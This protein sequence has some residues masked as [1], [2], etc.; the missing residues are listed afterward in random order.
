MATNSAPADPRGGDMDSDRSSV[1]PL[2]V[3]VRDLPC[4]DEHNYKV[5]ELCRACEKAAG[6]QSMD[7]AQRI[8]GLWRL[9]PANMAARTSLLM[10]GIAIRGLQVSLLDTNP[11]LIKGGDGSE[12]KTTR[13]TISDIPLSYANSVI[14]ETLVKLGCK[15]MSVLK[16]ECDRDERGK[17]TRW[18]NGRRFAYIELPKEPLTREV[19]VGQ[20][21]AKLYH[22]KQRV[23]DQRAR[24]QCFNCFEWGHKG[25][26]CTNAT[27][28]RLCLQ[29]SH[30][31]GDPKCG[32]LLDDQAAPS[33]CE[34]GHQAATST[35]VTQGS[36]Q[37]D[38]ATPPPASLAASH[39]SPAPLRPAPSPAQV[40]QPWGAVVTTCP[41]QEV[42]QGRSDQ[43]T[44]AL[45]TTPSRSSKNGKT[46]K[47]KKDK[48]KGILQ[49][50]SM[51]RSLS[52]GEAAEDKKAKRDEGSDDNMSQEGDTWSLYYPGSLP[53]HLTRTV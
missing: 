18:R 51:K 5:T 52:P 42:S 41:E 46:K 36:P 4:S 32:L 29:P 37:P 14:E 19:K 27:K 16:Y 15:L 34:E 21:L 35:G 11:F 2:F 13:V 45:T 30:K 38:T 50:L 7:G 43:L 44:A 3:K 26:Q 20:F 33:A 6:P 48:Q 12:V 24:S 47:D 31:Q 1:K 28:C 22:K 53:P 8:G 40:D 25:F 39:S 9:Y 23:A 10:S 17:L 49:M